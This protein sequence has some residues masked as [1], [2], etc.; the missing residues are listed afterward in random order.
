M[1]AASRPCKLRW[2]HGGDRPDPEPPV[3]TCVA[4]VEPPDVPA[5][6]DRHG[7]H[8]HVDRS[9]R[10]QHH[11]DASSNHGG[12]PQHH[13]DERTTASDHHDRTLGSHRLRRR[14]PRPE[15]PLHQRRELPG[16]PGLR[17]GPLGAGGGPEFIEVQKDGSR[18]DQFID[19]LPDLG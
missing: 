16:F 17:L 7:S 19:A 2:R 8:H 9:R 18:I 10:S 11:P 4:A 1:P 12:A 6:G 5:Q 13:D 3:A 15:H 14:R